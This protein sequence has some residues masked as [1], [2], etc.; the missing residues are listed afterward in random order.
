[1]IFF[2]LCGVVLVAS[3]QSL[4]I[5]F[6]GIE[7]ISI[8]LYI[9]TGSDTWLEPYATILILAVAVPYAVSRYVYRD[10]A[11]RFPIRTGESWTTL[12]R[13]YLVAVPLLAAG[14]HS[15]SLSQALPHNTSGLVNPALLVAPIVLGLAVQIV[16]LVAVITLM[17]E[18]RTGRFPWSEAREDVHAADVQV[19]ARIHHAARQSAQSQPSSDSRASISGSKIACR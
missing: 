7:I 13:W 10:H 4:L 8:P 14:V 17:D 19:G 6:L 12:E 5:L 9:L 1:M 16:G 3:F 11:V 18:V 15:E 2:I